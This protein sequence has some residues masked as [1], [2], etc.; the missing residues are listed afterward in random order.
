MHARIVDAYSR[1]WVGMF[2]YTVERGWLVCVWMDEEVEEG[3]GKEEE[4]GERHTRSSIKRGQ[5]RQKVP[6]EPIPARRARRIGP[7]RSDHIINRSHINRIV[8]DPYERR[9]YEREYPRQRRTG[10]CVRE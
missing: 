8:R 7:I 2:V 1:G 4:G 6:T 3:R 10:R 9:P 5:P